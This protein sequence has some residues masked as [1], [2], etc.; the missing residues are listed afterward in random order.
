MVALCFGVVAMAGNAPAQTRIDPGAFA[1]ARPN[2]GAFAFERPRMLPSTVYTLTL[3]G[4]A[5]RSIEPDADAAI[6]LRD[7][8]GQRL[9]P[10]LS[11]GQFC[12]LA[13]AGSGAIGNATYRVVGTSRDPQANCRR[14]FSRLAR[15]MPVAAGALGRSV[16]Q[17]IETPYGLGAERYRLVLWRSVAAARFKL[18]TVLFIPALRGWQIDGPTTHDGFVF[19]ADRLGDAPASQMSLLVDPK[20]PA[21][22]LPHGDVMGFVIDD[23]A[24]VEALQRAHT[25]D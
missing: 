10:I 15:K 4:M 6:P 12:E 13:A 21:L 16:F 9:G 19:V 20:R 1:F 7:V 25:I 22:N 11:D 3:T 17:R 8:H 14:Y 5:A 24:V 23:R 18:G 2:P